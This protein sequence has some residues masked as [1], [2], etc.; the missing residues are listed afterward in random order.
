MLHDLVTSLPSHLPY[1]VAL[2]L[3]GLAGNFIADKGIKLPVPFFVAL[4]FVFVASIVGTCYGLEHGP[5]LFMLASNALSA[6][7][8]SF[9]LTCGGDFAPR[10]STSL[11]VRAH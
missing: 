11:G 6:A 7:C 8:L 2:V 5:R 1:L 4:A 3:G 10:A 9:A